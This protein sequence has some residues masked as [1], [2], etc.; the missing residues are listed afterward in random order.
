MF[1]QRC[2]HIKISK[3]I[4]MKIID[5]EKLVPGINTTANYWLVRTEGGK[6]YLP[7][8]NQN[9]ISLS[10]PL[11][12][13]MEV[14][15][16]K[17]AD[18]KETI[19]EIKRLAAARYPQKEMPGLI[20]SQLYRLFFEIKK[21]DYIV[22]PN[23]SSITIMIG[24]IDGTGIVDGKLYRDTLKGPVLVEDQTKHLTVRWI[25]EIKREDFNLKLLQLMICRQAIVNANDYSFYIDTLIHDIYKKNGKYC[26]TLRIK[27][28]HIGAYAFYES[29]Y[30][31]INSAIK[32]CEEIGLKFDPNDIE[33]N[34]NLNSPGKK[35]LIA[36]SVIGI[37][38]IATII[39]GVNGGEIE[40]KTPIASM[41]MS[42]PGLIN[43]INILNK[44]KGYSIIPEDEVVKL[45]ELS[46][47]SPEEAKKLIDAINRDNAKIEE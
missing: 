35:S 23:A 40:F 31:L 9:V 17:K 18:K 1:V 43:N 10:Y 12:T 6:L 44:E 15:A 24:I 22:I 14:L 25:K 26:L 45:K 27:K 30:M 41:K 4:A 46:I 19:D 34:I 3:E 36:G 37:I 47:D 38:A 29:Q 32:Y 33:I 21:G 8:R 7:F 2:A 13:C 20:A 11:I 5:L 39:V 16:C 28:E 42:T